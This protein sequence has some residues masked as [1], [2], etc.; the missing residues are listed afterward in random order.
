MI[1]SLT[2]FL[3]QLLWQYLYFAKKFRSPSDSSPNSSFFFVMKF[4][5]EPSIFPLST[6]C[7]MLSAIFTTSC[8][9]SNVVVVVLGLL[10]T[11]QQLGNLGSTKN[12][13]HHHYRRVESH[14]VKTRR[15]PDES[16]TLLSQSLIAHR[17]C[18]KQTPTRGVLLY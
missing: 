2:P 18:N 7:S 16:K 8:Q 17:Q 3:D 6:T 11:F 13:Q 10:E 5:T 12:M 1:D 15:E 14:I 9:S 4:M